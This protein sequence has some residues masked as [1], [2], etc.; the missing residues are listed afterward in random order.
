M[1]LTTSRR[2]DQG[3]ALRIKFDLPGVPEAIHLLGEVVRNED[4]SEAEFGCG[5]QFLEMDAHSRQ[6]LT[7]FLDRSL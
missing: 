5:I 4:I 3:M 7:D 2:F 6:A 1:F